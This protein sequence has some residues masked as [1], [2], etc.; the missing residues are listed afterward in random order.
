MI[1][2]RNVIDETTYWEVIIK[3]LLWELAEEEAEKKRHPTVEDY[4]VHFRRRSVLGRI[5]FITK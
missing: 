2:V 4:F 3:V 1:M 5:T